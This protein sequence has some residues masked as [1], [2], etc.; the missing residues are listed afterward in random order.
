MGS[1][2]GSIV[3]V[4]GLAWPMRI[5]CRPVVP[6][7][8]KLLPRRAGVS[9]A[10]D[11]AKPR[12]EE[13]RPKRP[14]WPRSVTNNFG[15]H[16]LWRDWLVSWRELAELRHAAGRAGYRTEVTLPATRFGDDRVLMLDFCQVFELARVLATAW[17]RALPRGRRIARV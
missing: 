1:I 4:A 15:M 5:P 13:I 3:P 6:C 11:S 12:G 9:A 16:H 17:T 10:L 2:I 7:I 8:P 14:R